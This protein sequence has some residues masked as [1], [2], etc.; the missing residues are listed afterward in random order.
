MLIKNF[1]NGKDFGE[2]NINV[3]LEGTPNK[4]KENK[5]LIKLVGQL[6]YLKLELIKNIFNFVY[7]I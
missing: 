7:Q 2:K 1:P 4:V 3:I 5:E 6:K